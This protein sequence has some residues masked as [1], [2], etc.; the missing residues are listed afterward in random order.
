[1]KVKDLADYT[2]AERAKLDDMALNAEKWLFDYSNPL[3]SVKWLRRAPFGAPFISFTSFVAPLML[4][5][6]ITKPWKFLPY[7]ALGYAAKEWF[8]E[9]NDLDEEKYDGLKVSMSEYLRE[10]AFSSVFPAGV[11]PWPYVDENGRVVFQD[12]SYLFPWGMFS[13][14]GG[15][16]AE[17]KFF[18]AMKT[19][20]LMGGP[21]LNVASAIM[22]GIDPF[23]RQPIVDPTGDFT[24][25]AADVMWH[26]FNLTMPPM[27]HGIGQG[28]NQG[29][30]AVKRLYEAY[31]GQLTK[32]GE[33]RFTKTQ[34]WLR[35]F[36]Q[37]VTPIAVPEGRN[38]QLRY[39][40]S[41]LKKLERL[42]KRDLKNS[43]IMQES[44]RDIKKKLNAYRDK[45][46]KAR[47]ELQ[48]KINISTP[49]MS[50]LRQREEALRRMRQRLQQR[51]A[52]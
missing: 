48:K 5:T 35:M 49:P 33:A 28:P 18:D 39:E 12:I 40:Y 31:T 16:I 20:G 23:T 19:A 15:E 17:G 41:Q 1:M 24:E 52:S 50:L 14:M 4:E 46:I 32:E 7:Y 42:A 11:V 51:K 44:E 43:I 22:T 6:A 3:P 45:I 37:N 36:G 10:K 38:K 47:N 29:Y 2:P 21:T 8:K 25:Q 34:A 26:V 13:E 9:V 27:F 30:G